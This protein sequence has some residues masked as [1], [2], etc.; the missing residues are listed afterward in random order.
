MGIIRPR[1]TPRSYRGALVDE[2]EWLMM[3]P[4]APDIEELLAQLV[5]NRRPA[6]HHRAASRGLGT[7]TFFVE[8]GRRL[9]SARADCSRCE[10]R[11]ECLAAALDGGDKYGIWGGVSE[12]GRFCDQARA[13]VARTEWIADG[14]GTIL[15]HLTRGVSIVAEIVAETAIHMHDVSDSDE[16]TDY[17]DA[18]SWHLIDAVVS[19]L[20]WCGIPIDNGNRRQLWRATATEKRC[21]SCERR[22]DLEESA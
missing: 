17:L 12:K 1:A 16:G 22:R 2:V 19:D 20:T 15:R 5:N 4:E 13:D 6:W 9:N 3:G 10:V 18:S 14:S 7:E 21:P 11:A 8:T